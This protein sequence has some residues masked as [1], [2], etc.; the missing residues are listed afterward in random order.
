MIFLQLKKVDQTL[1]VMLEAGSQELVNAYLD[2]RSSSEPANLDE[3]ENFIK[4]SGNKNYLLL[5]DV[6]YKYK[7]AYFIFKAGIRRCRFDYLET[8]K[9]LL[10][11]LIFALNHPLYR[12]VYMFHDMDLSQ[13]PIEMYE[14]LKSTTGLRIKNKVC[15][16]GCMINI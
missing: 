4:Q 14:Q 12:K 9:I 3:F 16:Q 10:A 11:P 1:G 13:M 2:N 7:L 8:G 15:K 5:Y 6:I